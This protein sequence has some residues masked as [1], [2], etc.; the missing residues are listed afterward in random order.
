MTREYL[1]AELKP[2][3]REVFAVLIL[4]NQH[5][6]IRFEKLFF[7]TIN[8]S[9]VYPRIVVEAVLCETV[10]SVEGELVPTPNLLFV[11]S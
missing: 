2:E 3:T 9:A 1:L 4:D 7:G 11:S 10:R 5:Q 6:I 8:A